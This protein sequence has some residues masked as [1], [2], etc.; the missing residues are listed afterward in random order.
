MKKNKQTVNIKKLPGIPIE[1]SYA[2]HAIPA[3]GSRKDL[4]NW[5]II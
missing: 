1:A 2:L 3:E 4:R 5:K